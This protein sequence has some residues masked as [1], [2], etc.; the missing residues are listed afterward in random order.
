M[1]FVLLSERWLLRLDVEMLV[2][3]GNDQLWFG[4]NIQVHF[5]I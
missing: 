1:W 3:I 5:T 2:P 4:L